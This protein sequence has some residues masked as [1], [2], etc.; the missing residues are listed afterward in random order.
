MMKLVEKSAFEHPAHSFIFDPEDENWTDCFAE[1]ELN[2]IR[3]H[4]SKNPPALPR[5]LVA[6]LNKIKQMLC[7]LKHCYLS[8]VEIELNWK[9]L[10]IILLQDINEMHWFTSEV[11]F[12]PT[13]FH[14]YL[15]HWKKKCWWFS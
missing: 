11:Y 14:D 12:N 9:T 1:E 4:R 6:F 5:D 3:I 7:R 10:F 8:V 2:E 13:T 15:C